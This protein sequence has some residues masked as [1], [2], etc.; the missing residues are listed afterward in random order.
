[1]TSFKSTRASRAKNGS[2]SDSESAGK[3]AKRWSRTEDKELF[4]QIR[5]LEA[6]GVLSLDEILALDAYKQAAKHTGVR[7]LAELFGWK[8]LM[9]HLVN[10]V[11]SLCNKDFSVREI[12]RLKKIVKSFKYRDLDY[13]DICYE[14]PG[15]TKARIEQLCQ[16]I[17]VRKA[18]C[19]LSEFQSISELN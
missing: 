9:R 19:T 17:C 5:T 3:S 4:K 15:Q 13:D 12:K 14:F 8:G 16:E 7:I 2:D 10:R 1:M 18:N 11:K 6:Q